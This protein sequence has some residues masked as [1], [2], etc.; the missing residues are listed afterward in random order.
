MENEGEVRWE[1]M[2]GEYMRVRMNRG[3]K[4]EGRR[5]YI[6]ERRGDG[7]GREYERKGMREYM[8]GRGGGNEEEVRSD[9]GRKEKI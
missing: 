5:K 2:E 3:I 9:K 7:G 6:I 8:R 1:R 4:E